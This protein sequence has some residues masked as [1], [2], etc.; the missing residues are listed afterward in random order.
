MWPA[1]S[2]RSGP[3]PP[4]S[5]EGDN[6][7][8]GRGPGKEVVVAQ[9]V[10]TLPA[11]R[12]SQLSLAEVVQAAS[13]RIL[14][15]VTATGSF[16]ACSIPLRGVDAGITP[17]T[18]ATSAEASADGCWG[19]PHC[20]ASP[21]PGLLV[22]AGCSFFFLALGA[23]GLGWGV[24]AEI[25]TFFISFSTTPYIHPGFDMYARREV[26]SSSYP[27]PPLPWQVL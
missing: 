19:V 26:S 14:S 1:S 21:P 25:E 27:H 6:G 22:G 3:L 13:W 5:P 4:S 12:G 15:R 2:R 24:R 16:S 23:A 18:T 7:W 17:A 8:A 9:P 11:D 10:P 20:L